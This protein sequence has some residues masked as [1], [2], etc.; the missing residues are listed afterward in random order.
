MENL[1][2]S[3]VGLTAAKAGLERLSPGATALSV[4]AANAPDSDILVLAFGDRWTYLQNHRG[5]T[6]SIV[7]V[8]ALALFLPLIFYAVDWLWSRFRHRPPKVK[9][10]GLLI[11]SLIVSATH[12]LL[13]WTNNYGIRFLLPWN[14]KWFYGD[15]VFIADPYLWLILGGACFLLSARTTSGKVIWGLIA[16]LLTLLLV[17]SQRSSILPN[18]WTIAFVWIVT[19]TMLIVLFV[20]GAGRRWGS[21]IAF[22]AFALVL[23]YFGMLALAHSR[24]VAR[25]GEQAARIAN[26]NG[27][28]VARLA[29]MPTLANPFRWDCVFE[30]D[31]ATYRFSLGLLE[32][33]A[34]PEVI[35]YRQAPPQL[36]EVVSQ[37]RPAR[38]FLGFARFPVMQLAE[39]DCVTR[40]L[41]QLADLRYTEPG[42]SRGAFALE[43][44]IDCPN[45][46]TAAR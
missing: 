42:G 41:V 3:L 34:S 17:A 46:R 43:V 29:A 10:K 14:S 28:T 5:I 38:V 35:R 6:H 12:P 22:L 1:T 15:L 13:D 26:A 19:L 24:A 25:G 39:P 30:T 32:Q 36:K 4:L 7:G 9:L 37:Q 33:A 20:K 45:S 44:P 8:I 2:H 16:A 27:E 40:T 11:V 21:K 31:R 18:R 23:V